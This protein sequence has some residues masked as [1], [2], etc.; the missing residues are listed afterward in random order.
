M[1][2]K[3]SLKVRCDHSSF[4]QSILRV[5]QEFFWKI[6][7]ES[8]FESYSRDLGEFLSCGKLFWMLESYSGILGG[9]FWQVISRVM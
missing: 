4:K 2:L 8:Y 5:F 1:F 6:I 9:F 7:W 3:S